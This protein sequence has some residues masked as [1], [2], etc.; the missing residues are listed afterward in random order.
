VK[1]PLPV[2]W[3]SG[4]KVRLR[5]L[6]TEDVPLLRKFGLPLGSRG[7]IFIVQTFDGHDIGTLGFAI[8]GRQAA[9]GLN[10]DSKRRWTDGSA[11]EAL[12]LMRMGAFRSQPLVRMEALVRVDQPVVMS[13]YRRAGFK[14]EGVMRIALM[15]RQ[16]FKD[17]SVVS[18]LSRG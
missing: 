8:R 2:T 13:A 17:A 7:T 11:A 14:K 12:G 9:V 4:K 5:P 6:E 16:S 3:L 15:Q 10:M 1:N 18:V